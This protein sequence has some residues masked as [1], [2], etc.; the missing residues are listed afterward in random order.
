MHNRVGGEREEEQDRQADENL[1]KR[2]NAHR[3]DG[4][5]GSDEN[6]A[7][8]P[9]CDNDKRVMSDDAFRR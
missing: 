7:M 5:C 8:H 4:A 9:A 2:E 1:A 6:M 3:S